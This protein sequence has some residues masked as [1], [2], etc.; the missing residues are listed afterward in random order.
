MWAGLGIA[1]LA[2]IWL[3][4]STY[5]QS[6]VGDELSTLYIVKTNGLGGTI[7][8][9]SGDGEISPPLFFVLAWLASKLG[10]AP[11][12]VRMPSMLAG[13]A[14]L[15]VY[16]LLGLRLFSRR[17]GVIATVIA[18]LS[19]ILIYFSANGRAYSV[20]LFFLLVS[21]LAMLIA[22]DTGRK[23]WWAVYALA[24]CAAMYSHYTAAFVLAF[25]LVWLLWCFPAA[26]IPALVSNAA[27][28]L[29]FLPWLPGYFS[30]ADSPTTPVLEALQGYGFD[31][32][33]TAVEQL[34]FWDISPGDWDL[35]GRWDAALIVAGVLIALVVVMVKALRS[36]G[37]GA[38][39]KGIDRNLVLVIGLCL[40]T[41]IGA[42]LLGVVSTD[43]F[44]G[45]NLGASWSGIPLL[46]GALIAAAGPV[47]GIVSLVVVSAGLLAGSI[48]LADSGRTEFSYSDAAGYIDSRIGPDDAVID[49][50]HISPVPLTP[51]DAYLDF[52]GDE[53]RP[54]LPMGEPPFLP[55]TPVPD[56]AKELKQAFELSDRIFLV[57]LTGHESLVDD[58]A[59]TFG[60]TYDL[61]P[62]AKVVS[63]KT[64]DGIYPI[65]VT[66]I[67]PAAADP[68]AGS[69]P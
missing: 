27:A 8:F 53:Y 19:P 63:Q 59:L 64:F 36:T 26:R 44:G 10:S 7:D 20:M 12:L 61:P 2:G 49:T 11:E 25:Q 42:L 48:H 66:V 29:L 24:T 62:G 43:I 18:S 58:N 16:Y 38:W 45:R 57:T 65:T 46:V 22:E 1:V 68:G 56:T 17:A 50:S 47:W 9:V 31:A 35:D 6:L 54:G 34:L 21:T 30:D 52:D 4:L 28:G 32:K 39:L 15:P 3:R 40:A 33:R 13:L 41:P 51:L 60:L 37:L 14:S 69:S 5:G 67:D 23:R 55:T